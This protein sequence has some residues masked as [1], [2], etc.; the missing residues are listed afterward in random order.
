M[1]LLVTG[2]SGFIGTNLIESARQ[3]VTALLNLDIQPPYE[4]DHSTWWRQLDILDESALLAAFADFQ[5]THVIHLAARTDCDESTTV[6]QGYRANTEGTRNL[7]AAAGVTGSVERLIVA[8]TQFVF[9]K[10]AELPRGDEDFSPHTVYGQSKV[11]TEKLTRSAEL[12][13]AWTIVRPTTI[14]GPWDLKYR[15]AFYKVIRRGLYFHPGDQTCIRSY[16]YVENLVEQVF[17]L[18]SAPKAAVDHKVFYLGDPLID[19]R[20]WVNVFSLQIH[21]RKVRTIPSGLLKNMGLFGDLFGK[22]TG[23]RFVIDSSRF[24]SMTQDYLAPMDP[25]FELLGRPTFDLE[26]AVKQTLSWLDNHH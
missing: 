15:S 23:K 2:G 17:G 22:L 1:R 10:G 13:A 6:E 24:R 4:I 14:W 18:L 20:E 25:T 7:L 11:D 21:G 26:N 16:G 3:R 8:S 19:V 9:N 12:Q 5:P